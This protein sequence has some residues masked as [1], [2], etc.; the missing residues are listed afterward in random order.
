MEPKRPRRGKKLVDDAFLAAL[1]CGATVET[2]A[3]KAGFSRRTA[4]RRLQDAAFQKSLAEF[5]AETVRR[6]SA[7][8]SAAGPEAIKT[9]LD[10]QKPPTAPSVRLGAART[11]L[12]LGMRLREHN[13][14]AERVAA[15]EERSQ[16]LRS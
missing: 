10:L 2:A 14:L 1:A 12:E 6:S 16:R 4:F 13:D 5:K 7:A 15:L 9:L 8:L 11:I 3:A